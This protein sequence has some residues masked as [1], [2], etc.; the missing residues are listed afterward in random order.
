MGETMNTELKEKSLKEKE[1]KGKS[2]KEKVLKEKAFKE[3]RK[4]RAVKGQ[5]HTKPLVGF[6][7]VG[8]IGR[9][10][11]EA[12]ARSGMAEIAA[13]ADPS[14]EL[15]LQAKNLAP[16]AKGMS[17]L[18]D[19]LS[20]DL[21]GIVIAT[22]SAM[23]AEQAIIAL[24]RGVAVFCQKPLGRNED[25]TR[26]VIEAAKKNNRLLGVDLSYRYLK[27]MQSIKRIL[28]QGQI[29]NV[30]AVNLV[31]HN[32]YG[33]DKEWFYNPVLSGGGC[34]IDLGIHLVDLVLW[35]FNNPKVRNI[36]SHLFSHGERLVYNR[37]KVEDFAAA[38]FELDNGATVS[39]TCSWKVSAGYDAIIEA[40]FFG[41]EGGL[42][43]KNVNG[44][45]YDFKA[46]HYRWTAR[47]TLSEP[48]DNWGPRAALNW[49]EQLSRSNYYHPEIEQIANAASVIDGIYEAERNVLIKNE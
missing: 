39:L 42:S 23:H 41:T 5:L 48:P 47:E 12:I 37:D 38:K 2:F 21:D 13:I 18:K 22:P 16:Q 1:L 34:V 20:L 33:P 24:E 36:S 35:A 8:W 17:S 9:N 31:F 46:E 25:E 49:L 32:A 19:M 10:R 45:F 14:R 7:G 27:G 43:L 15:V 29:G 44:S 11:M 6:L 3:K 40:S 28:D 26:Q 30:F 4:G